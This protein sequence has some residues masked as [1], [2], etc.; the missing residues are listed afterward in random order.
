MRKMFYEIIYISESGFQRKIIEHLIS[1]IHPNKNYL[2]LDG[3]DGCFTDNY[4]NVYNIDLNHIKGIFKSIDAIASFP[5]L[6]C[7]FL[8]GTHFTGVN[9]RFFEAFIKYKELHLIDDGIGTPVILKNPNYYWNFPREIFK[10]NLV[11]LLVF[12]KKTRRLKTTK[13]LISTIAKY[14]TIYPSTHFYKNEIELDFLRFDYKLNNKVGFIGMPLVDYGMVTQEYFSKVLISLISRYQ[15]I[16][17]YPDPNEKWI[18]NQNIE[19]LEM[20]EKNEPLETF[21]KTDGLPKKMY[22]FTSSALLNIKVADNKLDGYYI[23]IPNGGK[24]R[25]YYYSIF[26]DFGLK[27]FRIN[28]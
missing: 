28:D 1:N 18:Y 24:V 2:W 9:C 4:N 7:D 21:L 6:S 26:N 20:V 14:Y 13:R 23:R 15:K 11:R 25:E 27:E 10:M 16:Y 3:K 12:G 22:T 17:Y 19:G 8:I 5:K